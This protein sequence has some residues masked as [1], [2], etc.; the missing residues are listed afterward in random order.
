MSGLELFFP[1]S[2]WAIVIVM[3]WGLPCSSSK[4]LSGLMSLWTH[5]E[6]SVSTNVLLTCHANN[7]SGYSSKQ[8]K[9]YINMSVVKW[10]DTHAKKSSIIGKS[11]SEEDPENASHMIT[12]LSVTICFEP[13]RRTADC[14]NCPFFSPVIFSLLLPYTHYPYFLENNSQMVKITLLKGQ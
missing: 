8:V 13:E 5:K 7:S 9:H 2:V 12:D 6:S 10:R 1:K 3:L 4:M 14:S 11:V